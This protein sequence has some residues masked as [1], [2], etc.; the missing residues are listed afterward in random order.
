MSFDFFAGCSLQRIHQWYLDLAQYIRLFSG[1]DS[2]AAILLEYYLTPDK[3][4]REESII[5][6]CQEIKGK[7]EWGDKFDTEASTFRLNELYLKKVMKVTKYNHVMENIIKPIF[8]SKTDKNR[9]IIYRLK[10]NKSGEESFNIPYYKMVEFP[11]GTKDDALKWINEGN[12]EKISEGQK[13]ILDVFVGLHKYIAR[14]DVIVDVDINSFK[15][16]NPEKNRDNILK[17]SSAKV[18]ISKW[19]SSFYDYYDFNPKLGFNL[20]NP[21][22][23]SERTTDKIHPEL[24]IVPWPLLR[25][26]YL[27]KMVKE[28]LAKS[29]Y[30]YGEYDEKNPNLLV[31][32]E[33]IFF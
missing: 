19:K 18:S 9:G 24:K 26:S 28:G 25:H 32:N 12:P 23:I 30:I 3:Q 7:D 2:T 22:Y 6:K 17:L 29:F 14:A 33:E 4:Q 11:E 1:V 15:I 27:E 5:N 8:L 13:E 16:E 10:N 21:D 31:K 20:P